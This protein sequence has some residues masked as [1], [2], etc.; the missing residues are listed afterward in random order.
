LDDKFS[1]DERLFLRFPHL[2]LRTGKPE[3]SDI[4]CPDLSVNRSKYSNPEDVLW[5]KFV[6]LVDWGI[7][8][9]PVGQATFS[10]LAVDAATVDF[11]VE[12]DP[13]AASSEFPEN[14]SHCEVRA[15]K[16]GQRRPKVSNT[17]KIKFRQRIAEAIDVHHAPSVSVL[18]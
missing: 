9:I 18:A 4:R 17:L 11:W 3:F 2:S 1:S 5:A 12:H 16:L 6:F 7:G 8:S 14:F 15:F 10:L 13:V